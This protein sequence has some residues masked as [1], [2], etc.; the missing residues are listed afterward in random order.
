MAEWS[1]GRGW[2]QLSWLSVGLSQLLS[3]HRT[4]GLSSLYVSRGLSIRTGFSPI[5]GHRALA[6]IGTVVCTD[7]YP[8]SARVEQ[9]YYRV[10]SRLS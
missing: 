9:D 5:P 10:R 4:Q 8:G 6:S 2:L 1:P 3:T 7:A